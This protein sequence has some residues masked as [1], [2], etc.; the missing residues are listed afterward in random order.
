LRIS[1]GGPAVWLA[2]IVATVLILCRPLFHPLVLFC[3][4][5]ALFGLAEA[6]GLW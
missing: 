6:L 1:P 4:G 5:G 3:A 2:A